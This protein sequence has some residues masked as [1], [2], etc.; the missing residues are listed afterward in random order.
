MGYTHYWNFTEA[1]RTIKNGD[2]KFKKAV[3]RLKACI[4]KIPSEIEVEL[5]DWK[6]NTTKQIK[7][8]FKLR[9]GDGKGEPVFTDTL[10]CFNGDAEHGNDYETFGISFDDSEFD[11]CKTAREPYD[12]AVCLAL[13]CFKSAFGNDFKYSSDG[14]IDDD[15]WKL[16]HKIFD[17]K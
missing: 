4:S 10:V 14:N 9:G 13:L 15:G 11:F 5:Y 3:N 7:F 1:P 2:K 6:T 12:V 16:A 17:G 8:P